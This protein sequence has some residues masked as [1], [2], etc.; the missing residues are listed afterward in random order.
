[1][2]IHGSSSGK[3]TEYV[4]IQDPRNPDPKKFEIVS[5]IQVDE[6]AVAKIRYIGVENF[7]GLKICVFKGVTKAQLASAGSL[8]PHFA[9]VRTPT[10]PIARFIPT[11]DGWINA[12]RF[13]ELMAQTDI[14]R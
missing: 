9:S 8:D 3:K 5:V 4:Y 13:A 14:N 1:M 7:E 10:V 11:Q 12:I 6:Y 2:G